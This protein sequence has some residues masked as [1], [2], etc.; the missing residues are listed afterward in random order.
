MVPPSFV[1]DV[2]ANWKTKM[3]AVAAYKSQFYNPNSK[4]PNTFISDPKFLEM[5]DARGKHFGA[6]IGAAYGEAFI[7]KQPPRIDDVVAAYAGREVT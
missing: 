4:E 1:V 7:S 5:I 3:R 6:L 2:T